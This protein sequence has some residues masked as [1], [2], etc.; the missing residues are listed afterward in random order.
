MFTTIWQSAFL[1]SEL[2]KSCWMYDCISLW[3][4]ICWVIKLVSSSYWCCRVKIF[5]FISLFVLF[6]CRTLSS[7]ISISWDCCLFF[8]HINF[9]YIRQSSIF[10]FQKLNIIM[11]TTWWFCGCKRWKWLIR[12]MRWVVCDEILLVWKV[13][14]EKHAGN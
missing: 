6:S 13:N 3:I 4:S 7:S 5:R 11:Y 8:S 9:I 1:P 2:W 14:S 12:E 10:F